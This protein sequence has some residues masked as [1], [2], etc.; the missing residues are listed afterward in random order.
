MRGKAWKW[1]RGEKAGSQQGGLRRTLGQISKFSHLKPAALL[2]QYPGVLGVSGARFWGAGR[3]YSFR[4]L[5][6]EKEHQLANKANRNRLLEGAGISERVWSLSIIISLS[7]L[8]Q[9]HLWLDLV[10]LGVCEM[11]EGLSTS[12]LRGQSRG[13]VLLLDTEARRW[14]EELAGEHKL[15]WISKKCKRALHLRNWIGVG[16]WVCWDWGGIE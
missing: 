6:S 4:K 2:F 12:G 16:E 5:L 9:I 15:S 1:N 14:G 3:F 7:A 13:I 8:C 10:C 11:V